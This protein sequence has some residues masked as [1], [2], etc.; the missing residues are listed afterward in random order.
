[1]C[2]GQVVGNGMGWAGAK[3]GEISLAR[4]E[5]PFGIDILGSELKTLPPL[6]GV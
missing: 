5:G 4:L 6:G 2:E 3:G 1:M